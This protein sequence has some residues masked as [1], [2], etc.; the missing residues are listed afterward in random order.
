LFTV[1]WIRLAAAVIVSACA[2]EPFF[3][4]VE[5]ERSPSHAVGAQHGG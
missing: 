3:R 1:A 2:H 4:G 5:P